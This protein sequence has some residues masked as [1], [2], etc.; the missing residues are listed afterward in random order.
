[1]YRNDVDA[2]RARV[3]QLDGDLGRTER[4]MG[5]ARPGD[6]LVEIVELWVVAHAARPRRPT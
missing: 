4:P 5:G 2:L 3:R 1:M 6:L